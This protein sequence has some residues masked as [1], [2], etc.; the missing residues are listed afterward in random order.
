[1][2]AAFTY[3]AVYHVEAECRTPLRTGGSS[4]DVEQILRHGE[5]APFLQGTSLAG[6]LRGWLEAA[7]PEQARVL[8][9]SP[10]QS[11]QRH[12]AGELIVSDALLKQAEQYIRPRVR[13]DNQNGV[14]ADDA[15][16]NVAHIAPGAKMTFTLARLSR[17]PVDSDVIRKMLNALHSGEI[18]LGALKTNGFGR[19]VLESAQYR[20]L[21]M[22]K[23]EDRDVWLEWDGFSALTD[24]NSLKLSENSRS[25]GTVF[26][27]DSSCRSILVKAET[28]LTEAVIKAD[29][30]EEEKVQYTPNITENDRPILPGSSVKGAVRARAE[31]IAD[32]LRLDKS[33][34]D[35]L[36]GREAPKNQETEKKDNGLPGQ[37][38]FEDVLLSGEAE[39]RQKCVRIRID[40]FTGSVIR[41]G[42]FREEPVRA[43]RLTLRITAPDRDAER[44][45]LLYAL[46]DLG[47]GLYNLGGNGAIGR[48]FVK[49]NFIA[50]ETPDGKRAVLHFAERDGIRRVTQVEDEDNLFHTW[51]EALKNTEVRCENRDTDG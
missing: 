11:G 49:V 50:A 22:R 9:G 39:S 48:G 51:T 26:T 37:V 34:T 35:S 42:L 36:F 16:F 23:P 12:H 45:L 29:G 32:F 8:F 33:F 20:V 41:Q 43:N 1:M 4:G 38:R 21:D 14:A 10:K 30:S 13:I 44:G 7:D 25:Q 6:A 19:V 5:G 31:A 28:P 27:V 17:M 2:A 46:R 3:A 24:S 47:L 18:T 15:K 40:R